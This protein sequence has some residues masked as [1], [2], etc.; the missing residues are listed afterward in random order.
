MGTV[1]KVNTNN[2]KTVIFYAGRMGTELVISET[3]KE[4]V[5]ISS[6]SDD[7]DVKLKE[8][9]D[10]K[11][12]LLEHFTKDELVSILAK[13]ALCDEVGGVGE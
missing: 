6:S 1:V 7:D 11:K 9:I 10:A 12:T 3:L 5:F 8:Y 13:F 2:G 4:P